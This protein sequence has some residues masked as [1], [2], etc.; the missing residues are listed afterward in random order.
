MPPTPTNVDDIVRSAVSD[1]VRKIA[2]A[3]VRQV[4]AYAAEELERQLAVNG[5]KPAR[6]T[7]RRPR[8]SPREEITKWV[9]DRSARRV[10]TFVIELTGGLDTKKRIIAKYGENAAFEKGSPRRQPRRLPK[11]P[12]GP[13]QPQAVPHASSGQ[14]HRRFGRRLRCRQPALEAR[15]TCVPPRWLGSRR[16]LAFLEA[17]RRGARSKFGRQP[18]PPA[19]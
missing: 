10:P 9:A 16:L 3:I 2:P 1:L 13:R 17:G 7:V 8:R 6:V 4:A 11:R 18:Q 5:T 19:Y 12:R 14:S 15:V